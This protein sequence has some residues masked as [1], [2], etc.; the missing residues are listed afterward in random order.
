MSAPTRQEIDRRMAVLLRRYK[1]QGKSE[2]W[3]ASWRRKWYE[4]GRQLRAGHS[5]GSEQ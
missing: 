5:E 4:T 2:S 3:L 1:R